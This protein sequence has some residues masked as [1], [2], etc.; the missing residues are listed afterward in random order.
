MASADKQAARNREIVL[1]KARGEDTNQIAAQHGL[2]PA[3]VRQILAAGTVVLNDAG[4]IDPVQVALERR[5]QYEALFE[6]ASSLA[7]RIPDSNPAPKVGALRLSLAAL[8]RLA[9]WDQVIGLIPGQLPF[10]YQE[11]DIRKYTEALFSSFEAAGIPIE[12]VNSVIKAITDGEEDGSSDS[13]A[14]PIA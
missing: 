2:T 9:T 7:E 14:P 13:P 10:V 1:A 12:T 8:D 6:Q 11:V 3:R 5:S 4:D